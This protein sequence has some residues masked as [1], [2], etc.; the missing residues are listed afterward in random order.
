MATV[1]FANAP[2]PSATI[3]CGSCTPSSLPLPS[4]HFAI[5]QIQDS[6]CLIQ[7]SPTVPGTTSSA[8]TAVEVQIYRH[9]FIT[10]FRYSHSAT[11]HP[12]DIHIIESLDER[13]V[14]NEEENGTVFLA[15]D[16]MGRLSSM[17]D[18][19]RSAMLP[20]KSSSAYYGRPSRKQYHP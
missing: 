3:S 15:R 6:V 2:S 19:R 12:S 7:L 18:R 16:V 13:S 1:T 5:A 11:I 10:I 20:I 14:L 8:L 4:M 9:E 17:T